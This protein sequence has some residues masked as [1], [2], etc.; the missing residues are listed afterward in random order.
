MST[1]HLVIRRATLADASGLNDIYNEA[2]LTTAATF[3]TEPKSLNERIQWLASHDE[4][5]P[6]L[7]ASAS[8]TVVGRAALTGWSDRAADNETADSS[9]YVD[10]TPRRPR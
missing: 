5:H 10:S 3:D 8:A 6:V 9:S 7:V 4:R 2:V 1:P